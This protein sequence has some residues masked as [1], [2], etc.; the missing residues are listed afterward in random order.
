MLNARE[1]LIGIIR[2][3]KERQVPVTVGEAPSQ[4]AASEERT[5][6]M[7]PS[8]DLGLAVTDPSPDI[9]ERLELPRGAQGALVRTVQPGG[10]AQEAGLR[11]GDLIQEINRR[12]IRSA[13]EFAET[14]RQQKS[15]DLVLL[16][17]RGGNTAFV[18]IERPGL[19]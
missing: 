3:G 10:P 6:P 2:E 19:G 12:E 5:P 16:V 1:E 14:V 8:R 7:K 4:R 9:L 13:R 17:N 11:P 15:R 18:V